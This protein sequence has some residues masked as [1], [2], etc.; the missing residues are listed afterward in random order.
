MWENTAPG[1]ELP[2]IFRA[3]IGPLQL[4]VVLVFFY[5]IQIVD[6]TMLKSQ[7]NSNINLWLLFVAHSL[8]KWKHCFY[9]RIQ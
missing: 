5:S 3:G 2:H 8:N 4:G 7:T 9:M 6:V 1:T